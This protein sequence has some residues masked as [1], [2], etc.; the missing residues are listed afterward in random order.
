M[1]IYLFGSLTYGGF[2]ENSSDIDL[3]VIT[4]TLL[5]EIEMEIIKNIHKK[6]I[7]VNSIW[8]GNRLEV[9]YTPIDM[10]KD[11]DIPVLPRPYYNEIFYEKATYGNEW[12]INNY[13]LLK[14]GKTIYGPEFKSLIKYDITINDIKEFCVKDFFKEWLPKIEDNDW[15]L[16]SHYQAYIVLNICRIIYT[17]INLEIGNKKES[18]RWVKEKYVKWKNLIEEAENWDYDKTMNRQNEIKEYIKY[19][20]EIIKSNGDSNA[21]VRKAGL[22]LLC[23][24]T[25]AANCLP[26]AQRFNGGSD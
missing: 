16:N 3:V 15:L 9:S 5:N 25:P 10:L 12:L 22:S 13:L 4:K 17:V 6:L 21:P 1:G 20:E 8:G 7:E 2:N 24:L 11:K 19:M 18:A 23:G 26:V 14:Y